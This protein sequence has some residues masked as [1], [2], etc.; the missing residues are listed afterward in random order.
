MEVSSDSGI[1]QAPTNPTT[2]TNGKVTASFSLGQDRA[3][4]VVTI[5]AKSGS[6]VATGTVQVTGSTLQIA[7]TPSNTVSSA[8]DSVNITATVQDAASQPLNNVVVQ[9]STSQG[10]LSAPTA[11]TD[12]SGRAAVTLTGVSSAATITATAVNVSQSAT[13]NASSQVLPDIA[14]AGVT[15]KNLLVQAN[16]T[17]IGPN[18]SG[19]SGNATEIQATVLGDIVSSDSIGVPVQNARVRYRIL[20]N[21]PLGSLTVDTRVNPALTDEAGKSINTFVSGSATSGANGVTV[22]ARVDGFTPPT[23]PGAVPLGCNANEVGARFSIAQQP[24]FVRVSFNN[25]IEKVDNELNY[26]KSFSISVTDSVGRGVPGVQVTATLLPT[27]YFKS[28]YAYIEGAWR[29]GRPQASDGRVSDPPDVFCALPTGIDAD[30]PQCLAR[31]FIVGDITTCTNEDTN[32]NGILDPTDNDENLDGILWP[33]QVAASSVLNDGLTDST[34]FAILKIKY[35][36]LYATWVEYNI[37]VT[38]KVGGTE[39]VATLPFVLSAEVGDLT[40]EDAPGSFITTPF[41]EARECRD[42]N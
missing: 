3:N 4:R 17:V 16:P 41:G 30:S 21:P 37:K 1:L 14:P 9:F 40:S 5:T 34:G 28:D 11:S 15:I 20:N 6:L 19:N 31:F 2:D 39:G 23:I 12:A 7:L 33:G 38:A 29:Q 27:K 36:Q 18:S 24:L 25:R 26:E 8:Q 35:G 22:C 13:V 32:N 10:A 42:R